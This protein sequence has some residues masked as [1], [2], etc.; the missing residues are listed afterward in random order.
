MKIESDH[1]IIEKVCDL[2]P[3]YVFFVFTG[4]SI[5]I[6]SRSNVSVCMLMNLAFHFSKM[7]EK[8]KS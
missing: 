3:D 2:G 1:N 4:T 6:Q 7:T 8:K 5:L